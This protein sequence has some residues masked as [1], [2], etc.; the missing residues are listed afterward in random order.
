MFSLLEKNVR[1]CWLFAF[2]NGD[3][4]DKGWYS[5]RK[6]QHVHSSSLAVYYIVHLQCKTIT[7]T[8]NIRL[9]IEA[10]LVFDITYH[11]R[12]SWLIW[13]KSHAGNIIK[14]WDT[15]YIYVYMTAILVLSKRDRLVYTLE[16][17]QLSCWWCRF[18]MLR[19]FPVHSWHLVV[20]WISFGNSWDMSQFF[21]IF[22]SYKSCSFVFQSY[23]YI[24]YIP[25]ERGGGEEKGKIYI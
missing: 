20:F 2:L 6:L 3:I 9:K 24:L 7:I 11:P 17:F 25:R 21:S 16:V 5:Q 19:F 14:Y 18:H 10:D 12:C 15:I 8:R 23:I 4:L 22:D 1:K 13:N